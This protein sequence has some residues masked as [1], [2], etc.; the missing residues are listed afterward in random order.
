MGL[1]EETILS[2]V[3]IVVGMGL[4]YYLVKKEIL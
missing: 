3:F 4:L 2:L 1:L